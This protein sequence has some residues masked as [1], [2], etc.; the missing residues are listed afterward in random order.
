MPVK[1]RKTKKEETTSN[2]KIKV[3]KHGHLTK[4]TVRYQL[5]LKKYLGITLLSSLYNQ[6]IK[7][8]ETFN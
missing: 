4:L 3:I 2:I 7:M 6:L 8:K 5:L 1:T